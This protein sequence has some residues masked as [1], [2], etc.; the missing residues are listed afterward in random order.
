MYES[1]YYAWNAFV[2]IR[3]IYIERDI[4][5][6]SIDTKILGLRWTEKKHIHWGLK[7]DIGKLIGLHLGC[8]SPNWLRPQKCYKMLDFCAN[9]ES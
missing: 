6:P 9:L 4:P 2:T 7:L 5:G 8:N 3:Y 1:M